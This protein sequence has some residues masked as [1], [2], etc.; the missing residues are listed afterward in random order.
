MVLI[1]TTTTCLHRLNIF[2]STVTIQALKEDDTRFIGLGLRPNRI[3]QFSQR[4]PL[5]ITLIQQRW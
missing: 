5:S 1:Y 4:A 2:H 3:S